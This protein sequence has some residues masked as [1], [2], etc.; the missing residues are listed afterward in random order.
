M[1]LITGTGRSG[2]HFTS[3]ALSALGVD[4]PHEAVGRD[5]CVSWKHAATGVFE[6]IGKGRKVLVEDPGFHPVIHQVRDPLKV[7]ASM[8]TFSLSSWYYMAR[9]VEL[10]LTDPPL[11][12]AM[13][14]WVGWN[15][16]IERRASWRFRIEDLDSVFPELC[17]RIG[18]DTKVSGLPPLPKSRRDSRSHRYRALTWSDLNQA[19]PEWSVEVRAMAERYGYQ[20]SETNF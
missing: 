11:L 14:A 15:E 9:S 4:A 13:R 12:T 1:F 18:I 20:V 3:A 19:S 6:Y 16:S 2:T 5:G 17:R 7:I 8:Q 10:R